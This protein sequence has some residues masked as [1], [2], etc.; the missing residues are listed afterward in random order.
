MKSG[1][2]TFQPVMNIILSRVNWQFALVYFDDIVIFSKTPH[3][4]AAYTKRFSKLLKKNSVTLKLKKSAFF[5]NRIDYFGH[6]IKPG[7]LDNANCIAD[8]VSELTV[9]TT[10]TELRSFLGLSNVFRHLVLILAG[11]S[12][13]LSKWLRKTRDKELRPLNNE[14]LKVF[15]TL[16]EKLILSAVLALPKFKS[17]VYVGK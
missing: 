10:V 6:V 8:V 7:R 9:P 1:Q 17:T 2:A 5:T 14:E 12:S 4:H 3:E 16:K 13:P 11:I 15:E